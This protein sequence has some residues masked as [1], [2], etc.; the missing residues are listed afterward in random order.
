MKNT[1]NTLVKLLLNNKNKQKISKQRVDYLLSAL[2]ISALSAQAQAEGSQ[3]SYKID[4]KQLAKEAGV[5]IS[6]VNKVEVKLA[7]GG[8]GEVVNL[9]GGIFEVTLAEGVSSVNFIVSGSGVESVFTSSFSTTSISTLKQDFSN[10]WNEFIDSLTAESASSTQ[11]TADFDASA[12]GLAVLAVAVSGGSSSSASVAAVIPEVL[13]DISLVVSKGTL[14]NAQVFLDADNDGVLDWTDGNSN[15]AWDAGEGEQ[16]ALTDDTGAVSFSQVVAT[17]L[18]AQ[19]YKVGGVSQTVDAVSGSNVENLQM[20]ADATASVITPLTTLVKAGLSNDDVLNILGL[21]DLVTAGVDINSYDPFSVANANSANSVAYEKIAA[22][23]FTLIN[24]TAELVA[25]SAD[26][27]TADTSFTYA[28]SEIITQIEAKIVADPTTTIDLSDTAIITAII[29]STIAAVDVAKGTSVA[30]NLAYNSSSITSSIATAIANTNAQIQT[31]T[32]FDS[33]AKSILNNAADGVSAEIKVAVEAQV[34]VKVEVERLD[35]IIT[36]GDETDQAVIDAK[37]SKV[38]E[39]ATFEEVT[40]IAAAADVVKYIS[41]DANTANSTFEITG[42]TSAG[43]VDAVGVYGNLTH[44]DGDNWVFTPHTSSNHGQ[45]LNDKQT[46]TETFVVTEGSNTYNVTVVLLGANDDA[47]ITAANPDAITEGDTTTDVTTTGTATHTDID[48]NN[49]DDVFTAVTA[50]T[51]STSG[52]GTYEVSTAGVWTYTLDS[53]NA[54]VK[55][56][57]TGLTAITDTITITAED[58]TTE[59]ITITIN[60][61]NDAAVITAADTSV[62]EGNDTTGSSSSTS[63]NV[64]GAF[65]LSSTQ[66]VWN[67]YDP[68]DAS[69]L[70]AGTDT[71]ANVGLS[72]VGSTL[73]VDGVTNLNLQNLI[74]AANNQGTFK[75]PTVSFELANVPTSIGSGTIGIDLLDGSNNS[76]DTG[77]RKAHIE[78]AI[79][80]AADGTGANLTVPA[81]TVSGYYFTAAGSKVEFTLNNLAADT[82]SLNGNG[83]DYPATL[84]IKLASIIDQLESVGSIS[85]LQEGVYH[86]EVS[87]DDF[88]MADS[89]GNI[90]TSISSVVEIT[91]SPLTKVA[92]SSVTA[93]ATTV[94]GDASHTDV[95]NTDDLFVLAT[96]VSTTYGKYSVAT[97]GQWTYTLDNNIEAINLLG[98]TSTALTDTITVTAEDGTTENITISINGIN[99]AAV[100][101]GSAIG[102]VTENAADITTGKILIHTDID[103]DN[104]DNEFTLVTSTVSDNGYGT[105][106]MVDQGDNLGDKWVYTLDN[107]NPTVDALNTG[108]SLVDTF[109]VEAEDGTDQVITVNIVG[110]NDAPTVSTVISDAST[111]EDAVYSYNASANFT[112]VDTGDGATYTVSGNP[113][114]MSIDP[115]TGILSGTP[116]NDDVATATNITVTRTDT[117]NASVSDTFALT[118]ANT[119]DA[120][121]DLTSGHIGSSTVDTINDSGAFSATDVDSGDVLSYSV[122]NGVGVYGTLAV[123]ANGAWTY[124]GNSSAVSG[125]SGASQNDTFTITVTDSDSAT[126]EQTVYIIAG[127]NPAV[128]T[129]DNPDAITEGDTTTDVTA[130]GTATHTDIDANNVD[131]VFTAVTAGTASTSDYGTYEVSTAGVWT[132]TLDSTNATV[133]A[134]NTGSIAITDTITIT[135]E[136]GTTESI[137]ITINGSNDAPTVSTVISDASTNEDAVYSYD[138]S[139]NFTDVDT[140]DGATYTATLADDTALPSWLSIT[141][142]G[143]LSGTPLN[144]D[145]GAIEVKVTRTDTASTSVSDTFTLTVNNVNDAPVG[146]ADTASTHASLGMSEGAADVVLNLTGNDT[147]DENDTTSVIFVSDN[148]AGTAGNQTTQG[149]TV[150][151]TSGVVT[152]TPTVDFYGTDTFTYIARDDNDNTSETSTTTVTLTVANVNDDPTGSVTITGDNKTGQTLTASNDLTDA[153]GMG[154]VSYQWS[155][156]GVDVA[157]A[158]NTT[159]VLVDAD[160]GSVFRVTASYTDDGNTVETSTSSATSAVVDIVKLVQI[161]NIETITEMDA[162]ILLYGSDGTGGSTENLIKFDVYLDAEGINSLSEN[163]AATEIRG[164]EFDIDWTSLDLE[165][166]GVSLVDSSS[167]ILTGAYAATTD[168]IGT[169][170][171]SDTT[172]NGAT[173]KVVIVGDGTKIVN[174]DVSDD[175]VFTGN[176]QIDKKIAT[177][178]V[179]PEDAKQDI[180][181]TLN[182]II[183]DTDDGV[184]T[185]LSYSVDIL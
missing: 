153:D 95:D 73:T 82:I 151:L 22:Q 130:T 177:L 117:A 15:D 39:L 98:T 148:D 31:I 17:N 181:I 19:A 3:K 84:D 154:T 147:D 108:D 11:I 34:A 165:E 94:T 38:T 127:N 81:Q 145:V 54:T 162:S 150:T 155:K 123:D 23:T 99:D 112:D 89:N 128:I 173:G 105:F 57:N 141:S 60:G 43:I 106:K 160:I 107:S 30:E 146:V 178:Y 9:G 183:V 116:D 111:N 50:G 14:Q 110:S 47:I 85:L 24:A 5:K 75:S 179:N 78:I 184:V 53:T 109:T 134:L 129:A 144:A 132:Y 61:S 58:G 2:A 65:Q 100:I 118:V 64:A 42:T 62:A 36:S 91:D 122:S 175:T 92:A 35:A 87:T 40:K 119:N 52:Y 33:A 167:S 172:I 27:V 138:T 159:L 16:W 63:F 8:Q 44:S 114:W 70:D 124:T 1:L 101:S 26:G 140:G 169:R 7:E 143:V 161:R 59:S 68:I 182:N 71:Q 12:L 13:A 136:D 137:T 174:T 125:L 20:K 6:D 185:P 4:V 83:V 121:T 28:L 135:A 10:S 171:T 74:N 56:L 176:I 163:S 133:K 180:S 149:G 86:L 88:P 37:E 158:T 139:A 80:W 96:D 18:V 157:G 104:A 120:P 69:S 156:D 103:S 131:N 45:A 142:A 93:V 67:D 168:Y 21:G 77:E 76:H 102:S 66:V 115:A 51:A 49:A 164:V 29:D 166:F 113:A 41:E 55:A 32:T 97:D 48:A 25:A 126:D 170:D 152:Y 46:Y 90:I 72:T 79:D